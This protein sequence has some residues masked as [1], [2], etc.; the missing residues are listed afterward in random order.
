M[1][2]AHLS[3]SLD[4]VSAGV[5]RVASIARGLSNDTDDTSGTLDRCRRLMLGRLR[6]T[7]AAFA[8]ARVPHH[9]SS[10]VTNVVASV[11][12][13]VSATMRT[14]I[15]TGGT[16]VRTRIVAVR[17]ITSGLNTDTSDLTLFAGRCRTNRGRVVA[18]VRTLRAT[19]GGQ[20]K[21]MGRRTRGSLSG[22]C[23][24]VRSVDVGEVTTIT[25]TYVT[26]IVVDL[27][28]LVF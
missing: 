5:S 21:R 17:T 4:H 9:C 20:V 26:T 12:R 25:T 8:S 18:S 27:I 23:G 24:S 19:A 28:T 13:R 14:I 7:I 16:D 11:G 6:T 22:V 1:I 10:G 15:A 3:R 2:T